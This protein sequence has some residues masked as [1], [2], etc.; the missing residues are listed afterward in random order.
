MVGNAVRLG[1]AS[2]RRFSLTV[3]LAF[4]AILSLTAASIQ[5]ATAVEPE[6]SSAVASPVNGA[7]ESTPAVEDEAGSPFISTFDDGDPES[8]ILAVANRDGLVVKPTIVSNGA[9]DSIKEALEKSGIEFSGLQEDQITAVNGKAGNYVRSYDG[10]EKFDFEA[11]A[12][13]VSIVLIVENENA[14]DYYNQEMFDAIALMGQYNAPG[15][16]VQNY[17]PAKTAYAAVEDNFAKSVYNAE[18]Y[19]ALVEA[20][21]EYDA[22]LAG[23][24]TSVKV[25]SSSEQQLSKVVVTDEW[26]NETSAQDEAGSAALQLVAGEYAIKG[27]ANE[28]SWVEGTITVPEG[29]SELALEVPVPEGQWIAGVRAQMYAGAEKMDLD[30]TTD[31]VKA[32]SI[33]QAPDAFTGSSLGTAPL[34][35]P[36]IAR[37][38]NQPEGISRPKAT[39]VGNESGTLLSWESQSSSVRNLLLEGMSTASAELKATNSVDGFTQV[40]THQLVVE[41]FPVLTSFTITSDGGEAAAD[42]KDSVKLNAAERTVNLTATSDKISV[43]FGTIG[44]GY[45]LKYEGRELSSI[46]LSEFSSTEGVYSIPV[47]LE[48]QESG[49]ST[50]Y[51]LEIARVAANSVTL[52]HDN[53]VTVK[54]FKAGTSTEIEPLVSEPSKTTYMLV[55]GMDYT[56]ESTKDVTFHTRQTFTAAAAESVP[57]VTPDSSTQVITGVMMRENNSQTVV[58]DPEYPINVKSDQEKYTFQV[59]DNLTNGAIQT[60]V[61]DGYTPWASYVTDDPDAPN[62]HQVEERVEIS[63]NVQEKYAE[64]LTRFLDKSPRANTVTVSAEKEVD[65]VTYF[66][67][68][69]IT[70]QRIASLEKL[71]A[72]V[73]GENVPFLEEGGAKQKSFT[74]TDNE[75]WLQVAQ[76]SASITITPEH[77]LDSSK[78]VLPDYVVEVD[79][80]EYAQSGEG[81][82]VSL[83]PSRKTDIINVKVSNDVAN[84]VPRTYVLHVE[85]FKSTPATFDV[86]AS[87]GATAPSFE[88]VVLIKD[89]TT[90][91]RL[92]PDDKGVYLLNPKRTYS[93]SATAVGYKS[94]VAESSYSVPVDAESVVI[95]FEMEKA[96]ANE[97]LENLPS[98]WPQFRYDDNNNGSVNH[99]LPTVSQETAVYWAQ[100]IGQGYSNGAVSQPILVDG[101]LYFYAGK[102]L[103]RVDPIDGTFDPEKDVATMDRTSAFAINSPLYAEGMIFVGLS[104]GGVQAFNAATMESVWL[105]ND[106]LK[107]QPNV[108][109]TYHDGHVFTGFWNGENKEGNYVALSI[110]DEDPS[111]PKELKT[112]TWT[113]TQAGGFYWA[114][115][116]VADDYLIVGTDDGE[117]GYDT[118]YGQVLSLNTKTGELIDSITMPGVGDIRSSMA[119]DP[120]TNR[121]YFTSK[122]AYLGSLEIAPDGSFVEDSLRIVDLGGMSTSTPVMRNGRAYIGVSGTSQFGANSGHNISVIDLEKWVVAYKVYTTGYP[123]VSGLL[124]DAYDEGDGTNYVY[125]I[126]NYTPGQIRVLR[127]KAG[128]VVPLANDGVTEIEEAEILLTPNGQMAQYAIASLVSDEYGFMYYKN[129]SGYVMAV[130]PTIEKIEPSKMP[131]KTVYREGETFDP[132]GLE[133]TVTYTNGKTRIIP[134]EKFQR[135]EEPLTVD[136]TEY[137]FAFAGNVKNTGTDD[138]MYQDKDGVSGVIYEAPRAVVPIRVLAADDESQIFEVS[139]EFRKASSEKPDLPESVTSKLPTPRQAVEGDVVTPEGLDD[140]VDEATDG[141]WSFTGWNT[142]SAVINADTKFTGTWDFVANEHKVTYEIDGESPEG[143]TLPEEKSY[144][145]GETVTVAPELSTTETKHDGVEGEWIFNGWTIEGQPAKDFTVDTSDVVIVGSWTFTST[146][147]HTASFAFAD[148]DQLPDAVKSLLPEA[149]TVLEGETATLPTFDDVVDEERDGVWTFDGWGESASQPVESDTT[150]IGNWRFVPNTYDVV[151]EFEGADKL[152]EAVNNQLPA[153][154]SG[155][156]K[157][158]EVIPPTADGFEPVVDLELNGEWIF[159]GWDQE[160]A[161]IDG[162]SVVITGFWEFIPATVDLPEEPSEEPSE[163]LTELPSEEPSE[164]PTEL[165]SEEPTEEPSEDESVAPEPGDGN[166]VVTDPEV[167]G[168]VQ[169][170][171]PD[172]D[173]DAETTDPEVD[174]EVQDPVPDAD[175][176]EAAADPE[177]ES[178]GEN[179]ASNPDGDE[180]ADGQDA[181]QA[182]GQLGQSKPQ[183]GGSVRPSTSAQSTTVRGQ[184]NADSGQSVNRGTTNT[185]G[186]ANSARTTTTPRK[187]SSSVASRLANTGASV[188]GLIILAGILVLVGVMLVLR[189][190]RG[191]ED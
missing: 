37:G 43:D 73:D 77:L 112:P 64:R 35:Y 101:K 127:D 98:D 49:R 15:N 157:G 154:E 91:N 63:Y 61:V 72:S 170:P 152:P 8:F 159:T 106:A 68:F 12:S 39:F 6:S 130:G 79:G 117:G 83:N 161:T 50:A 177:G 40:Q 9:S 62:Y 180:G 136:Q 147:S 65:G 125:F 176:E 54:L 87:D 26:G 149:I 52:S 45:V 190:R 18:N 17:A 69:D 122:G 153:T 46:D 55:P 123:Q 67:S 103:L 57:V 31:S 110:T 175:G 85:K 22:K 30:S 158:D 120:E 28:H 132:T 179:S 5:V 115:A 105:Y 10:S 86:T 95:A 93:Y 111:D 133:L 138:Q 33:I 163:E 23:E 184:Q 51:T 169:D 172:A 137:L 113:H 108:P 4:F 116:Y 1:Q 165:P 146:T 114:G 96:P 168:E 144:T 150:F 100:R 34:L 24:K 191:T 183:K 160:F 187:S 94:Y 155:K 75:Y 82:N 109:L 126:D 74:G 185:G 11:P 25:S 90:G 89:E 156:V 142:E 140:V 162:Q 27:F 16:T 71:S 139:Y 70:A 124:T 38:E 145:K 151:Y 119:F 78:L 76:N 47:T 36:Y 121:V 167:N 102:S 20:I 92:Y 186:S 141:V 7:A 135:S 56:Y 3:L 99:P 2:L 134:V 14:A 131:V 148:S 188:I 19:S 171:A 104:N 41:R 44:E 107:G 166:V 143:V 181:E 84:A 128:Q 173:G 178:E 13:E 118:G 66:Q 174:G 48:H 80:Q 81:I 32:L 60:N 129:D 53:D 59:K 182:P 189:A 21:K 29:E 88:P 164:E 42:N 97:S 58:G